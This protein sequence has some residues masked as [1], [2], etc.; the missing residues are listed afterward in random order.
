METTPVPPEQRV[1]CGVFDRRGRNMY[2]TPPIVWRYMRIPVLTS[3]STAAPRSS[4]TTPA[5]AARARGNS[6]ASG[7]GLGHIPNVTEEVE[8]S[9]RGVHAASTALGRGAVER[10]IARR[11]YQLLDEERYAITTLCDRVDDFSGQP[12]SD[13]ERTSEV[14]GLDRAER[15]QRDRRHPLG[16]AP[17]QL[18]LRARGAD[19]RGASAA[20]GEQLDGGC[21]VVGSLDARLPRP[22]PRSAPR[23]ARAPRPRAGRVSC[24]V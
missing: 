23:P 10:R 14:L 8:A 22:R 19:A 1:V 7:G 3:R 15:H 13:R 20:V 16:T 17:G 5:T 24:A 4:P 12:T 21:R 18:G 9:A 6:R 2:G 11:R